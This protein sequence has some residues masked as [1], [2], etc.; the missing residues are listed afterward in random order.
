MESRSRGAPAAAPRAGAWACTVPALCV[1]GGG[2]QQQYVGC[3]ARRGCCVW[4][5]TPR[6]TTHTTHTSVPACAHVHG[7]QLGPPAAASGGAG[8]QTRTAMQSPSPAVTSSTARSITFLLRPAI[9]LSARLHT[10][11]VGGSHQRHRSST[12]GN[13]GD[14][15]RPSCGADAGHT[16]VQWGAWISDRPMQPHLGG[17]VRENGGRDLQCQMPNFCA[18]DQSRLG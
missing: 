9:V 5:P 1:C 17:C 12:P 16:A 14:V 7:R 10:A 15:T 11:C 18:S 4:R 2:E 8:S 13:A 3:G 6:V